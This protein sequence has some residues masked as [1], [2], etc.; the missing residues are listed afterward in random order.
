MAAAAPHVN[1]DEAAQKGWTIVRAM[2]PQELC[3]RLRACVDDAVGATRPLEVSATPQLGMDIDRALAM[4]VPVVDSQ[5]FRHTVRQPIFNAALA[6]AAVAGNMIE[7]HKRLYSSSDGLRLMQQMLVRTDADPTAVA[8]G[9]SEP[10]GWHM[11]TAFLPR[12]YAS[13]PKTNVFHVLTALNDVPSG[14]AAL[15]I[16]PSGFAQSRAYTE[17][18][19]DELHS[20]KDSDFRTLL[21]PRLLLEAVQDTSECAEILLNEGDSCVFDLM[22][23]HSAASNC[24]AGYSRY[25]LFQTF[26]DLSASYALLPPRGASALPT[27]FPVEFRNALPN[28]LHYLLD[29]QYP[30]DD[31]AVKGEFWGLSKEELEKRAAGGE[32]TERPAAFRR[33]S[34]DNRPKL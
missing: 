6:E 13:S 27:K 26:F 9:R 30:S 18:H 3:A 7:M 5:N 2:F 15:H 17:E 23:T 34:E 19:I 22:T 33:A 21:R 11:D 12:H 28:D 20:L 1:Y 4:R 31:G 24:I 29:W 32:V 25:V 16:V 8:A 10:G 14:G